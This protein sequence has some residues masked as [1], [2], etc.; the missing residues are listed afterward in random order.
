MSQVLTVCTAVDLQLQP[1]LPLV[2][3]SV[4]F[5]RAADNSEGEPQLRWPLPHDVLAGHPELAQ[6]ALADAAQAHAHGQQEDQRRT[7]TSA[8]EPLEYRE[9][10]GGASKCFCVWQEAC[11]LRAGTTL[12]ADQRPC[13]S[14]YMAFVSDRCCCAAGRCRQEAAAQPQAPST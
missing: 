5:N 2:R 8:T 10:S 14:S 3:E 4:R 13:P 7:G 6:A 12:F 1:T 11:H 9:A